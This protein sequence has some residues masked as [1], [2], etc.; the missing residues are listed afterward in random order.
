M[1]ALHGVN[2]GRSGLITHIDKQTLVATIFSPSTYSEVCKPSPSALQG[3]GVAGYGL[4][5]RV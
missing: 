5:S 3:L 2:A 4:G 1:R